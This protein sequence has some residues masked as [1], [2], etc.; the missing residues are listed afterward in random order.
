MIVLLNFA[1]SFSQKQKLP[2]GNDI[3]AFYEK[4]S[5]TVK[6]FDISNN[7]I[8]EIFPKESIALSYNTKSIILEHLGNSLLLDHDLIS[9]KKNIDYLYLQKDFKSFISN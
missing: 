6:I 3:F 5:D 9:S 4:T 1:Q 2:N 8:R 7:L